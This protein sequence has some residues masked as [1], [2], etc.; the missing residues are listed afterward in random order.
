M[1][2]C[3]QQTHTSTTMEL[4]EY[5]CVHI[6][7]F[8]FIQIPLCILNIILLYILR[9]CITLYTLSTNVGLDSVISVLRTCRGLRSLTLKSVSVSHHHLQDLLMSLPSITKLEFYKVEV[10]VC[11]C[12][13]VCMYVCVCAYVLYVR[14]QTVIYIL[15]CVCLYMPIC[16]D[17]CMHYTISLFKWNLSIMN[18]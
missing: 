13:C 11:A 10:K 18:L 1:T 14:L 16:V 2:S 5:M 15:V 7:I 4:H 12:M 3:L 6:C 8:N 17:V 9:I